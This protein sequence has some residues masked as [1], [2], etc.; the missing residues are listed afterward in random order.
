[1]N[2][3]D[4][5]FHIYFPGLP[6]QLAFDNQVFASDIQFPGDEK[7]DEENFEAWFLTGEIGLFPE[8]AQE[9][10][11]PELSKQL[12]HG[13]KLF[14]TLSSADT[15]Q[16]RAKYFNIGSLTWNL[17][18]LQLE[19]KQHS[20]QSSTSPAHS[21]SPHDLDI[22]YAG[23]WTKQDLLAWIETLK[24]PTTVKKLTKYANSGQVRSCR[25]F[26]E[27]INDD[28][29]LK[30]IGIKMKSMRKKILEA[31]EDLDLGEGAWPVW[32]G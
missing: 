16:E 30:A 7:T 27:N 1:M 25:E 17:E 19:L 3:S 20:V 21:S 32:L 29:G 28:T 11:T 23:E 26:F 24:K 4:S 2:Q 22:E 8:D 18:K 14:Q 12:E 5:S 9:R 13:E 15:T 6:V 31:M 10:L